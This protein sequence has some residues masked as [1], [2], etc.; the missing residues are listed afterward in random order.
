MD[1]HLSALERFQRRCLQWQGLLSWF[2][3]KKNRFSDL[4]VITVTLKPL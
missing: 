3:L 1:G 2:F 4:R